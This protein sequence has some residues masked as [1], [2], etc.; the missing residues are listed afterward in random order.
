MATRQQTTRDALNG[1]VQAAVSALPE[2]ARSGIKDFF[3]AADSLLKATTEYSSETL[4]N[5]RMLFQQ[6]LEQAKSTLEGVETQAKD[7][8]QK[9]SH[10]ADTY[11]HAK[12]WQL[13]GSALAVGFVA[14]LFFRRA[15]AENAETESVE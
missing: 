5:A 4:A 9:A 13:I 1:G 14:G 15:G 10:A 11:V 12:P 6:R 3:I 2:E 8:Y 7:G